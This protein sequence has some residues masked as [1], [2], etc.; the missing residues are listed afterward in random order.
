MFKLTHHRLILLAILLAA[1]VVRAGFVL[2]TPDDRFLYMDGKDYR[3]ISRNLIS[4]RGYSTSSYRSAYRLFEPMPPIGDNVHPDFYRPPLLSLLG[5]PLW[6]LPGSWILWARIVSV[7]LGV[8][9]AFA[10]YLVAKE[11][12][13]FS[14]GLTAAGVF[15]FYPF[16]VYWSS[17]WST[18]ILLAVCLLFAIYLLARCRKKF[19]IQIALLGGLCLGLTTLARPN[20]LFQT[21]ALLSYVAMARTVPHRGR[22]FALIL[23]SAL[24]VLIPWSVRNMKLTGVPNPVTFQ[25]PYNMWLGTNERMYQIYRADSSASTN[26]YSTLYA[27]EPKRHVKQLESSGTFDVLNCNAYW[28]RQTWEFVSNNP[29]K[30]FYIYVLRFLHFWRFWADPARNGLFL[31]WVSIL[32]LAPLSALA[33]HSLFFHRQ[34]RDP[35]ILVPIVAGLIGSLP[36]VFGFRLRFPVYD[37]FLV[38]LASPSAFHLGRLGLS[39][40]RFAAGITKNLV[41]TAYGKGPYNNQIEPPSRTHSQLNRLPQVS[42]VIP[43]YNG[44]QI[45]GKCLEAVY[46]SKYPP[47]EVIVVDDCSTDNSLAVARR[48]SCRAVKLEE[49]HGTAKAKNRG[50]K[51]ARGDIIFFTDA[52]ILLEKDTLSLM[53]EDF[54]DPQ[55]SAVVG[56][57]SKEVRY[58]NFCSEYKNLW[59]HYTYARQSP[60]IGVFYTSAAAIR[61][62]I[63]QE[64]TGFNENYR[65]ASVTEDAEFGQRLLTAGHKIYLDKRLT[66]KHLKHYSFVGLIKTDFWRSCGLTKTFLRNKFGRIRQKSYTSV[67]WFFILSIFLSFFAELLLILSIISKDYRFL[68]I[69]LVGWTAILLVNA[70]FLNFLRKIRGWSFLGKSCGFLLVDTSAVVLGMLFAGASFIVGKRF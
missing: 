68:L 64:N 1:A 35:L 16:A 51:E 22:T 52:D 21:L 36:F 54:K 7:A 2:S 27:E 11:L 57:L 28:L 30:T 15:A 20:G 6:L 13:S 67:P 58:D 62:T 49:K 40:L 39:K 43:V 38:L 14:V 70:T 18:E 10:V 25:G 12:F 45:L 46:Q 42:V 19:R 23:L 8:L 4:G 24:V 65:G 33:V 3:D 26:L 50:V 17:F 41:L 34:S 5:V 9:A 31:F 66:V 37:P 69:A 63:F 32:T 61:K 59:M 55:I 60:F 48:F 47:C 56:L 29:G 44:E 53:I